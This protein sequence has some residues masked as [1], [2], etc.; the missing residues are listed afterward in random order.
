VLG[1]A[2]R[3]RWECL[4]RSQPDTVWSLLPS[5]PERKVDHMFGASVSVQVGD[6]AWA[7][8]WTDS[9]LPNGPICR[10]AP[11]LFRAVACR[12][13]NRTV[14]DAL[15]GRQWTREITGAPTAAVL[16]EYIHL[17][18]TLETFQLSP[19]TSDRFI[20][21]WT[22]SGTYTASSAYRA[23]FIGM[24][25][26]PG[27][28]FVWR[29]AVPPKVK[30]FFWLAL[31]GRLWTADRRKRHGLQ[32]EATCALCDQ[33]GETTDHLLASCPFT[34]EVWARLLASAGHQ[35]LAPGNDSTLADWWLLTRD[36]VPGTFRRAF[37]SLVLLVAWI[38]W[39]ERN[40]RTFSNVAMTT[41]QVLAVVTEELDAYIGAGYRCLA[42][43][44]MAGS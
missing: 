1:F 22:A 37:D 7:R 17:W 24:T 4:R 3:L 6:G 30:F 8:F 23:F 20:W 42:S 15:D 39:K 26:L 21:K 32:P 27:A 13:R 11:I 43:F 5:K 38:M 41:T 36:E 18:D 2:L 19:H 31:H 25:S 16:C 12:R 14:K 33:D 35:H 40:N 34:R 10:S 29:A 9:W 44:F 28:K